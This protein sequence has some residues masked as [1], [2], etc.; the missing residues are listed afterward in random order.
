[1]NDNKNFNVLVT[2]ALVTDLW[3]DWKIPVDFHQ[4]P[5]NKC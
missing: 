3:D 5:M 4:V 1:M 2:L